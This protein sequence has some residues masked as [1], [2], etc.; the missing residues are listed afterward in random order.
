MWN[1]KEEA[2]QVGSFL[3]G[4]MTGLIAGVTLGLLTAPHRGTITRRKIKRKIEDAKD[5]VSEGVEGV[6]E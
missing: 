5:Q 2:D 4:C 1:T 6:R 3:L